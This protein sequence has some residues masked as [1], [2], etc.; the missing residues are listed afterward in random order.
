MDNT[1][2]QQFFAGM[3]YSRSRRE[4]DQST[5]IDS[6]LEE[7]LFLHWERLCKILFQIL[8]SWDEAEDLVLESFERLYFH[9]PPS[10]INLSGWLYRTATNMALNHLRSQKRREHYEAQ[11]NFQDQLTQ[12]QDH[13]EIQAD[14]SLEIQRVRAVLSTISP[15]S[16]QLLILR[17]SGWSYLEI[18]KALQLP[19]GSIG[20][21][22]ARAEK[23]FEKKFSKRV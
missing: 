2:I 23:E 12:S 17:H 5:P 14:N 19:P 10:R 3:T 22:L 15:R 18:A 13:L 7:L 20:T 16:A 1:S 4:T 21:L 9:P 11:A 8:G 6:E